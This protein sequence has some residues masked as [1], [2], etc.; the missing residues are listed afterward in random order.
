[1]SVHLV[2]SILKSAEKLICTK[3]F[4]NR[5][6]IGV[7]FTRHRKI[8]FEHMIY[9]ILQMKPRSLMINYDELRNCIGREQ[10]PSIS[11]QAL[12]KARQKISPNAF[13]EL[14]H[15][16]KDHFYENSK[17]NLSLWNGF[18]VYA[19][20]GSTL[21]LPNSKE[22]LDYWGSNPGYNGLGIPLASVSMI[23]DVLNDMLIDVNIYPYRKNERESAQEHLCYLP[24]FSNSILLFDRGYPSETLYRQL[25][26]RGLYYLI[27]LPKTHKKLTSLPN[28]SLYTFP[29]I[30]GYPEITVRTINYTD[31]N[32]NNIHFVTNLTPEQFTSD[33]LIKLYQMRWSIEC[34]YREL[35]N[36]LQIENFN[37][38]KPVCI[39]QEFF[40]AAF[41]SNIT[42]ILKRESDKLIHQQNSL[43]PN[44]YNYQ[45][46]R[47]FLLNRVK[48]FIICMLNTT[49][50][51]LNKL[52][53]HIIH[54]AVRTVSIIRPNRH[55]GRY[56]RHNRQRFYPNQKSCF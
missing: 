51:S 5:N 31:S 27:R 53:K 1:M 2:T 14:F 22:N 19:V 8:S 43:K 17:K 9:Y 4:L 49:K 36:R 34:K 15:L 38:M 39:M 21:Q 48:K 55:F 54:E 56:H 11:K 32:Q 47:S 41:L 23:Y 16:S 40:T 24:D 35:K 30:K 3:E 29:A 45:T 42:A 13:Y 46:N 52:L 20:D 28:D 37:G 6:R 50:R 12:S 33:Q 44:L 7:G 26:K 10:V 25:S 18:H